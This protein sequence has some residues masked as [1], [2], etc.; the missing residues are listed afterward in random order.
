MLIA[1]VKLQWCVLITH[2]LLWFAIELPV[3]RQEGAQQHLVFL[4]GE[5]WGPVLYSVP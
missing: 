5:C 2:L 4:S 1:Q 3:Q